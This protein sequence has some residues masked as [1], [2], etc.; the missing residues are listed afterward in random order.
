MGYFGDKNHYL[1]F[2]T[3]RTSVLIKLRKWIRLYVENSAFETI[4]SS[5]TLRAILNFSQVERARTEPLFS[6]G[7]P[8]P[9]VPRYGLL[10]FP[11]LPTQANVTLIRLLVTEM[12][13]QLQYDVLCT[14]P[15]A[16]FN[17][18]KWRWKAYTTPTPCY[19]H[20][21]RFYPCFLTNL[22]SCMLAAG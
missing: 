4:S 22:A 11:P 21:F 13:H 10:P 20:V 5:T 16:I 15:E 12:R 19:S 8:L 14:G 17:H 2:F 9:P 18:V 3:K 1:F 6:S 7:S